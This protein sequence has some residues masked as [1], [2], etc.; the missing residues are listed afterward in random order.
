MLVVSGWFGWQQFKLVKT[1]EILVLVT[2]FEGPE[3]KNYFVTDTIIEN[4]EEATESYDRVKIKEFDEVVQNSDTARQLG[5]EKQ[6]SIV[7][8]GKYGKTK[9]VVPISVNIEVMKS[10]EPYPN[11]EAEARGKVHII[12]IA[13]LES[14]ILPTRSSQELAYLTLIEQL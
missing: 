8:W 9:E 6:A 5:E 4:L 10:I 11:L 1:R 12:A 13:E 14:F 7:I 2:Q 3:L